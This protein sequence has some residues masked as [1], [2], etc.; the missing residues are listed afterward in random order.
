MAIEVKDTGSLL[1]LA[2]REKLYDKLV[3]Q[4]NKDLSLANVEVVF[5]NDIR[6]IHLKQELHELLFKLINERFA[7]YLNLL[8]IVDV[9][10]QQIKELEGPDIVLLSEQVTFLVLKREWQ[11]VWYKNSYC[12]P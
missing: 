3:V 10:E 4:L 6:P 8:Y 9:P 2:H 5:D 12:K 7:D 11:K 1:K